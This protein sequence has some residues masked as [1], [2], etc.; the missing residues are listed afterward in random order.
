MKIL[1]LT[2]YFPP[3]VG[4]GVE[5][6]VFEISRRLVKMGVDI[7][8]LTLNTMMAKG[9]EILEGIKVYR[10][11]PI[12]LTETTKAQLAISPLLPLKILE[13]YKTEK[14]DIIHANNRFFF[15]TICSVI[16]KKIVGKPLVTTLHLGPMSLDMRILNFFINVYEKTV[17]KWIITNS[18]KIIAV[19]NAV[20]KHALSLGAPYKKIKVVPN[21]VDLKEFSPG[22]FRKAERKKII[23][24]GR[25]FPNKG[26]QYLVEAAPIILARHPD[27]EFIIIGKGPMETELK[28]LIGRLNVEHAFRF[29]GIVPSI[30]EIMR[31]CDIFVR[32]SLTEGM[33]LTILEA[34][35]CGLPIIASKIPGTSE[36]VK[37]GETGILIKPGDV[38]QL[39]DAV[40]KLIEDENYAKRI[41]ARAY[42]FIRNHY[43]WDRIAE[44]YLKIYN[45]VLNR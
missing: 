15:T 11:R 42:E 24:I 23:F 26:I 4:G 2:D 13:V 7:T 18:D 25:L 32:P 40:I 10:F 20:M 29:L 37:D 30:P 35:A 39:S 19:S 31:E 5:K 28:K 1:V 6:V 41:R 12:I 38:K 44:E 8:V 16:L 43:S 22:E 27:V 33:P 21:G 34:M 36:V 14:P 45:E 17:S 3:H 9:F